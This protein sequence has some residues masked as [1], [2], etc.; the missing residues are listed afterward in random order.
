MNGSPF[1]L[2]FM[3]FVTVSIRRQHGSNPAGTVVFRDDP[4]AYLGDQNLCHQI[5]GGW[6]INGGSRLPVCGP[7]RPGLFTTDG[8]GKYLYV[9]A[10]FGNHTGLPWRSRLTLLGATAR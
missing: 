5:G 7:V 2:P 8:L 1:S 9:T 3:G 10:A 4:G 6:G